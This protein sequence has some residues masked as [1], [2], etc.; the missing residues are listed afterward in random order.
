MLGTGGVVGRPQRRLR[1]FNRAC[2][3]ERLIRQMLKTRKDSVSVK[4]DI[5]SV[6]LLDQYIADLEPVLG[7]KPTRF[8]G[9]KHLL[10][11]VMRDS[12]NRSLLRPLFTRSEAVND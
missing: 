11:S 5:E 9:L 2:T 1:R 10:N 6:S 12:E 7:F 8:Q 4:L 3:E